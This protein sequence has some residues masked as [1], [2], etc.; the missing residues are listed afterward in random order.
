MNSPN[1]RIRSE[2]LSIVSESPNDIADVVFVH[3]LNG[4]AANTWTGREDPDNPFFWIADLRSVSS[5]PNLRAMTFGYN[6]RFEVGNSNLLGVRQHA[7]A[8]LLAIRNKRPGPQRHRPLL[9][10]CHS[11]GGL[12]V[13]QALIMSSKKENFQHIYES[14]RTIF[15]FGTPHRGSRTIGGRARVTL[16]E[17][18]ARV[19]GYAVPPEIRNVLE[20]GSKELFAINDDYSDIK[21]DISVVNF[22]EGKATEGLSDLVVDFDSAIMHLPG[23]DNICLMRTH[24]ELVRY[25]SPDDD[26]YVT[27]VET[28]AENLSRTVQAERANEVRKLDE[29]QQACLK[30]LSFANAQE[31]L[32]A[33]DD[34]HCGTFEWLWLEET[35]LEQWLHQG[36]GIFW[37]TGKAGCGKST[38]MKTLYSQFQGNLPFR[39]VAV[40]FFFNSR[41]SY[42]QKSIK[43]LLRTAISEIIQKTPGMEGTV[44]SG[45]QQK[46]KA[47]TRWGDA[48]DL[49]AELDWNLQDLKKLLW[50]LLRH[51]LS[52]MK[53]I[54]IVDAVDECVDTSSVEILKLFDEMHNLAG[55]TVVKACLSGRRLPLGLQ[56]YPGFSVDTCNTVDIA[57]FVEDELQRFAMPEEMEFLD[58][59]KKKIVDAAEGI[60]LW[61]RLVIARLTTAFDDGDTLENLADIIS[62]TPPRLTRLFADILSNIPEDHQQTGAQLFGLALCAQRPLIV[63]EVQIA[64]ESVSNTSVASLRRTSSKALVST[65]TMM[66]KIIN[67]RCGGLLEVNKGQENKTV[68]QFMHHSIKE[69]LLS[70]DEEN[71]KDTPDAFTADRLLQQGHTMLARSCVKYFYR[72]DITALSISPLDMASVDLE[73][74]IDQFNKRYPFLNYAVDHWLDHCSHAEQLGQPQT[75]EILGFLDRDAAPFKIWLQLY[76]TISLRRMTPEAIETTLF[77]LAIRYNLQDLVQTLLNSGSVDLEDS[78]NQLDRSL[79]IASI[80]GHCG[81]INLLIENGAE[82][83]SIGGPFNTALQAAAF[84]GSKEA[85]QVLLDAGADINTAGGKLVSALFAASHQGHEDVVALLIEHGAEVVKL[86]GLSSNPLRAAAEVGSDRVVRML[87]ENGADA[88]EYDEFGLSVLSWAVISGSKTT[89]KS[90]ADFGVSSRAFIWPGLNLLHWFSLYGGEADVAGLLEKDPGLRQE[91]LSAPDFSGSSPLHWAACNEQDDALRFLLHLGA[92]PTAANNFGI[93]PLHLASA[94]SGIDYVEALLNKGADLTAVDVRGL[95]AVHYAASNK[96]VDVL[97]AFLVSEL[98]TDTTKPDIYGRLPIHIAA[99]FGGL[100]PLKLLL[101]NCDDLEQRDY[102]G[103]TIIHASARHTEGESLRYCLELGLD[104]NVTDSVG[105]AVIHHVFAESRPLPEMSCLP[106]MFYSFY[107]VWTAVF[108]LK[109][110]VGYSWYNFRDQTY[111]IREKRNGQIRHGSSVKMRFWPADR[112]TGVRRVGENEDPAV[113]RSKLQMLLD[114]GVDIEAKDSLGNTVLHLASYYGDLG[115]VEVL[116]DY[117]AEVEVRN[118]QNMRPEDTA[119]TEEIRQLLISTRNRLGGSRV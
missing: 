68:V 54:F 83:N 71:R 108:L 50:S 88:L 81:M 119:S 19:A 89:V 110:G 32:D 20:P 70:A 28:L 106:P 93:T 107:Q 95:S 36:G 55:G 12:V 72:R 1:P 31:R 66:I 35:G 30:S 118:I 73:R 2:G 51:D 69:F 27:V 39:T 47:S 102:N 5:L 76:Y 33:I 38:L 45:F 57:R 62:K 98:D 46:L 16:V 3:G 26:I 37:I 59:M 14:T 6:A 91:Q 109:R 97:G 78:I 43:G 90:L 64:L 63:T 11:L 40:P 75:A 82:V 116:L 8:L 22:Y 9:F 114:H 87:L 7:E 41:G 104:P 77:S 25:D 10:I 53:V 103:S 48:S 99:E 65:D 24:Q 29:V 79:Q 23:E 85:V 56:S 42:L 101:E 105:M 92:D 84:G 52:N 60:F 86:G 44:G 18:L 74:E 113:S 67:S 49:E 111:D 15:F 13:K 115:I 112:N 117:N 21:R 17:H 61:A 58:G 96:S 80:E 4:H 100:E 34:P 94:K